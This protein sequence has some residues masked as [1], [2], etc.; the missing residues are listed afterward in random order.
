MLVTLTP[1][2]LQALSL[3]LTREDKGI[4]IQSPQSVVFWGCRYKRLWQTFN[5]ESF[6]FRL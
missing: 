1:S 5:G 4:R 2:E 6:D 3:S